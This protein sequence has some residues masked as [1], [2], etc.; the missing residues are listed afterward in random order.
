M[1]A[2]NLIIPVVAA[3]ALLGSM[4]VYTVKEFETGIQFR[5]GE[6]VKTDIPP[7]LHFKLPFV[8]TIRTFDERILTISTPPDRFLTS[9]KKNLIVDYYI[10]WQ[11]TDAAAYYRATR[12]DERAAVVRIDQIVKDGMKSQISNLTIPEVVSGDRDLFMRNVIEATNDDIAGLGIRVVD[13][14]IMRI[15]LPPEV[16]QSVFARMEQERAA[17][18]SAV[19]S[20]GQEQ[21]R[22]IM[23]DAD[24]QRVE[25][26]A[27]ANREAEQLRGE[28]DA[29]AAEI[30]GQAFNKDREF[31][32]FY[33]S[34][35]AYKKAFAGDNNVMVLEPN[36]SF[37]R[38]FG[39]QSGGDVSRVEQPAAVN[40]LPSLP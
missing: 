32:E 17:V 37:F 31:F 22:R 8:N 23:A 26:I 30:Y 16:S 24:R 14:R 15:E 29:R 20:R 4:S 11:I 38:Y 2:S 33:R 5:L 35:N 21:A 9:E 25:I 40:R 10:K 6:I 12:G 27:E 28:G 19:R 13:V 7:G 18:A 34:I 3:V 1:A 39:D 36:S